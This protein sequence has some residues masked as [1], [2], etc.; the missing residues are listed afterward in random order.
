MFF[1]KRI[2]L[3]EEL[4]KW[5]RVQLKECPNQKCAEVST[6]LV[7]IDGPLLS[8]V[9]Y[10]WDTV[11]GMSWE[12]KSERKAGPQV[13]LVHLSKEPSLIP[14]SRTSEGLCCAARKGRV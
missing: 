7:D 10:T 6:H 3:C 12:M 14:E 2:V 4:L 5:G 11:N 9:N 8:A 1:Q 13:I